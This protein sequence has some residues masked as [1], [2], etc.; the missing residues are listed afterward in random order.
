MVKVPVGSEVI[1]S[2]LKAKIRLDYKGESKP[3]KFLFGGK[4]VEEV[5]EETREQKVAMLRNVPVQGMHIEDIDMSS[6]VYVVQDDLSGNPV[7]YAPVQITVS[8][9]SIE[10]LGRFIVAEE[11][12][13]IEILDP[14]QV[15]FT[16]QDIERLLF[17]LSQDIK[18]HTGQ[19][20]RK[21]SQ[22]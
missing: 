7:A 9:D 17:K 1:Q 15:L 2:Q 10:D 4:N 12:R 20:E 8:T 6:D 22:K 13:K 11:F 14:E 3:T 18:N 19:L 16:R 5:A 21:Y